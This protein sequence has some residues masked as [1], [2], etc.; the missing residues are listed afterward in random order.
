MHVRLGGGV[1]HEVGEEA[2]DDPVL[3]HDVLARARSRARVRIASLLLAALDEPVGLEPLQHLAGRGARDAEHLRDARGDRRR[4]GGRL[5]LAD[6]EGEEVDR[7]EVV[8]DRV[9]APWL[10]YSRR[11][12]HVRLALHRGAVRCPLQDEH[13]DRS[14]SWAPSRA[15]RSSSACR[16]A[17]SQNV[18]LALKAMLARDRDR[19]PAL[20]AL[21]RP[22]GA[23]SSRSRT[24]STPG[25]RRLEPLLRPRGAARRSASR[26]G[27][28]GLVYY[29]RWMEAQRAEEPARPGRGLGGRVRAAHCVAG[30][31]RAA[32]SPS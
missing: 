27:L 16:S 21:G 1:A 9:P 10:D 5:V 8:V 22:L 30:C 29:D 11:L 12:L 7:L 4:P 23:A 26:V 18:S 2:L 3:A 17:G 19:H 15:R 6:R 14:S 20:P 32:G 13:G 24:R 25:Q 31:R 28:L